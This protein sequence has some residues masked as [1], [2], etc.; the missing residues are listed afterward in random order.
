[1][2]DLISLQTTKHTAKVL[3]ECR[4]SHLKEIQELRSKHDEEARQTKMEYIHNMERMRQGYEEELADLNET[5]GSLM[6]ELR[7]KETEV[8]VLT[9]SLNK[10]SDMA[11]R[12][13]WHVKEVKRKEEVIARLEERA[14]ET[15]EDLARVSKMLHDKEMG[16]TLLQEKHEQLQMECRSMKQETSKLEIELMSKEETEEELRSRV[17]SLQADLDET[18]GR[19]S[20][21]EMS[22]QLETDARLKAEKL[23]I[24]VLKQQKDKEG[25]FTLLCSLPVDLTQ[26]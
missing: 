20:S 24:E 1:M 6:R 26:G 22:L 15:G 13:E 17:K 19:A 3:Q 14:S 16:L 5:I 21:L 8:A 2:K 4:E 10:T 12:L 23:A 18:S 9:S 25:D 11:E 7:A